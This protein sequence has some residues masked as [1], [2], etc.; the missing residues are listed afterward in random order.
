MIHS[1]KLNNLFAKYKPEYLINVCDAIFNR[2]HTGT[3]WATPE[4]SLYLYYSK[5]RSSQFIDDYNNLSF[6][7][8]SGR[9]AIIINGY[10]EEYIINSILKFEKLKAFL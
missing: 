7:G 3:R 10:D 9:N 8:L 5:T 4:P 1:E 2:V 6:Y